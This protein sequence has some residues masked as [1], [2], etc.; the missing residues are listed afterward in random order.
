MSTEYQFSD[1]NL[2]EKARQFNNAV[3][4][5]SES[6]IQQI[7]NLTD[8]PDLENAKDLIIEHLRYQNPFLEWS[9]DEEDWVIGTS[10]M[11]EF[12]WRRDNGFS[13]I[14]SVQRFQEEHPDL[15]LVDEYGQPVTIEELNRL[16]QK[17]RQK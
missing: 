14:S 6:C 7:K 3:K 12:H 1:R 2:I 13:D 17:R 5:I 15:T 16:I 9:P 8:D 11:E 10:T 4:Q